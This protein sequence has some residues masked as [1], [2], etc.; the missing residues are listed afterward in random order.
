MQ[1]TKRM[2][3]LVFLLHISQ[4]NKITKWAAELTCEYRFLNC[5]S[6]NCQW[7]LQFRHGTYKELDKTFSRQ[8][9]RA[10]EHKEKYWK[11]EASLSLRDELNII[12]LLTVRQKVQIMGIPKNLTQNEG[13]TLN[14]SKKFTPTNTE[15]YCHLHLHTKIRVPSVNSDSSIECVLALFQLSRSN[16][17]CWFKYSVAEIQ[18]RL[19]KC[20]TYLHKFSLFTACISLFLVIF[21]RRKLK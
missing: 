15:V 20:K 6:N 9:K 16:Y 11:I 4:L 7:N 8:M 5:Q 21:T 12:L 14:L 1:Y 10:S 18:L 17:Y 13:K 19:E 3:F 2:V